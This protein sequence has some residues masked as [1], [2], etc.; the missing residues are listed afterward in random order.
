MKKLN[1]LILLIICFSSSSLLSQERNSKID[2]FLGQWTG[3]GTLFG[4]PAKFQLRFAPDLNGK[5][6]HLIF[7]NE[8]T[9]NEKSYSMDAKAYYAIAADSL[10]GYWF[11]SRGIQLPVIVRVSDQTLTSFWGSPET[12]RGKTEYR[13]T[14]EV[15]L[16][17][18]YVMRNG[19][20]AKFGGAKYTRGE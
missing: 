2:P 12:E 20:Y 6:L 11:D 16:T 4:N 10:H 3:E 19:E 9:V 1:C 7:R 17:T 14:E 13:L 8:Y 18:D 5:F 15:L